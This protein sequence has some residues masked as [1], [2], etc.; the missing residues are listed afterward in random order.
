MSWLVHVNPIHNYGNAPGCTGQIMK[1][2]TYKRVCL[3]LRHFHDVVQL[4]PTRVEQDLAHD[5]VAE[6]LREVD[7]QATCPWGPQRSSA[8]DG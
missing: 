2:C 6:R 8:G 1:S 7:W 4:P 3:A 5:V